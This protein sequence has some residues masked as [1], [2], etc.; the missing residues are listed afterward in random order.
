MFFFSTVHKNSGPF[1]EALSEQSTGGLRIFGT[2]FFGRD[3]AVVKRRHL[4]GVIGHAK[5]E[6]TEIHQYRENRLA[7]EFHPATPA[8]CGTECAPNLAI[9]FHPMLAHG[10]IPEPFHLPGQNAH[11]GWAA[12]RDAIAPAHVFGR[13]IVYGTKSD[14]CFRNGSGAL[15]NEIRHLAHIATARVEQDKDTVHAEVVVYR[16]RADEQSYANIAKS[17]RALLN[18]NEFFCIDQLYGLQFQGRP[19][20]L[21]RGIG[22]I[23]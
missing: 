14:F 2:R 6:E 7:R 13:R 11:I 20:I 3:R 8:A 1:C 9:H 22:G 5:H 15:G 19:L 18:V 12:D 23:T 10:F 17:C 4:G 21:R 16:S